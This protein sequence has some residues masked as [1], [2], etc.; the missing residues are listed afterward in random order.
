ML[1][2]MVEKR[3]NTDVRE[4]GDIFRLTATLLRPERMRASVQGVGGWPKTE[5]GAG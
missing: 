5:A 4:T 1:L 3:K 2:R